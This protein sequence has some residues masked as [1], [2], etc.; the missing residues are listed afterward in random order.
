MNRVLTHLIIAFSTLIFSALTY[1]AP[2]DQNSSDGSATS[3]TPGSTSSGSGGGT[4][5]TGGRGIGAAFTAAITGTNGSTTAA[6]NN[7]TFNAIAEQTN[8]T[9]YSYR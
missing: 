5:A 7:A 1:G 6:A 2:N 8:N 9:P 3:Q 4:P